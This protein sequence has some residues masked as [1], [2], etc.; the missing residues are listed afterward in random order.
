MAHRNEMALAGRMDISLQDSDREGILPDQGIEAF[1]RILE[2]DF[3][4]VVVSTRDFVKLVE[5]HRWIKSPGLVEPLEKAN[6][7]KV[8]HSRPRLNSSFVAPGNRTEMLLSNIWKAFFGIDS[9][10]IHDNFF[11]L[12]ATS[13]DLV[14][15]N[16]RLKETFGK[17][18]PI[19]KM[20][21]YPTIVSLAGYLDRGGVDKEICNKNK[22]TT[23]ARTKRKNKLRQK[24]MR[25]KGTSNG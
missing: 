7:S 11:E 16:S 20:F 14:Q 8:T 5:Q 23:P 24:K 10:G 22:V 17:E 25:M 3:L 12:G 4:Q 15:L 21:S 18:I 6:L 2:K 19:E 9:I 1:T 13:L